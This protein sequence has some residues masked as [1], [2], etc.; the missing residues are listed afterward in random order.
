MGTDLV[1]E[2][3]AIIS[4]C[5]TY[6][7]SLWRR[8]SSGPTAAFI[9]LNPSTADALID[10]P[11][12]RKCIGFAV[13][14]GMGGIVVGNLFAFRATKPEDMKRA[15][16]PVGPSNWE[17]L[18]EICTSAAGRVT[19]SFG[20]NM[21]TERAGKVVCAWGVNGSHQGQDKKFLEACAGWGVKPYA[22]KLTKHGAPQHPLYV[23]YSASPVPFE[24]QGLLS[25]SLEKE[26][27]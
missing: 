16:A 2:R 17:S 26:D 27:R 7:Y 4:G 3:D 18:Q 20:Q 23:P 24:A 1:M 9:M 13:R 11:T 15:C 19:I 12:I 25:P 5:S 22:L 6:R 10:D 21:T 14:W 8:W